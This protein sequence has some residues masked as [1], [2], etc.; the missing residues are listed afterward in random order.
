M[1]YSTDTENFLIFFKVAAGKGK[2]IFCS[3]A[4]NW[5]VSKWRPAYFFFSVRQTVSASLVPKKR[6]RTQSVSISSIH[7][8]FETDMGGKMAQEDSLSD[9]MAGHSLA[10]LRYWS[11]PAL[12][13]YEDRNSMAH[14]VESRVPFLD[15]RLVEHFLS[16]PEDFFFK[17]GRTKRLLCDAVKNY[18]PQEV[19]SRKDKFGFRT[20]QQQWMI[21]SFGEYLLGEISS[22]TRLDE[23]VD[24]KAVIEGLEKLR[25]TNGKGQWREIF[26]LASLICW[27]ERFSAELP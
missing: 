16:L 27:A 13:R 20:P 11:L 10:D 24:R 26:R 18:L 1:K 21:G 19:I 7:T 6:Y 15:H 14:S 12:L 17:F 8:S 4:Y 25:Q 22:I 23:L 3:Q 5:H 9:S 2:Y